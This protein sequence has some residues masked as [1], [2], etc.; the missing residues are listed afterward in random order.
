AAAAVWW[1]NRSD[2]RGVVSCWSA[3]PSPEVARF[4]VRV[5]TGDDPIE[6]CAVLWVD[7][8]FAA[9]GQPASQ[10]CLNADGTSAVIPGDATTCV[11]AGLEPIERATDDS[12][13][14]DDIEAAQQLSFRLAKV[15]VEKCLGEDA[16]RAAA[17]SALADEQLHDWSVVVSVTFSTER[18][19]GSATVSPDTRTIVIA[20]VPSDPGGGG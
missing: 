20:A 8:T 5:D 7:G 3:A 12:G 11:R 4:E 1:Q 13:P 9:A 18:P 19:C 15:F 6:A 17:S 14:P 10:V 16:S 2:D